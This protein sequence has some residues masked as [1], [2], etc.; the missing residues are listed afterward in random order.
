MQ[1]LSSFADAADVGP[2]CWAVRA[3]VEGIII[4]ERETRTPQGKG[5]GLDHLTPS[6]ED[7]REGPA[8]AEQS[9]RKEKN[10]TFP[11]HYVSSG[12]CLLGV[13]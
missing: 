1:A 5:R 3:R 12:L 13:V 8:G 7:C 11:G 4:Q 9:Q 2:G 6:P 10:G